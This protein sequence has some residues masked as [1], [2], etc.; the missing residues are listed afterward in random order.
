MN[1]L[2]L[3]VSWKKEDNY[4]HQRNGVC[5]RNTVMAIQSLLL[6]RSVRAGAGAGE[7][8]VLYLPK[9]EAPHPGQVHEEVRDHGCGA[10][11]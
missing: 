5:P 2:F 7:W 1:L 11:L 6:C 8:V 4:I 3:N 9:D 10:S